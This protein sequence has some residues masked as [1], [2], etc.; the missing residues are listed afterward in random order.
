[1]LLA[2]AARFLL[3]RNFASDQ[4]CTRRLALHDAGFAGA[5]DGNNLTAKYNDKNNSSTIATP[6]SLCSVFS[7]PKAPT[8]GRVSCEVKLPGL[9]S[10]PGGTDMRDCRDAFCTS[11]HPAV[12]TCNVDRGLQG[13]SQCVLCTTLDNFSS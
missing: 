6:C 13:S 3:L 4:R 11:A 7:R 8:V 5:V 1:M 10:L 2:E 9:P 12:S